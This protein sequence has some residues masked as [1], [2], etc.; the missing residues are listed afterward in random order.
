MYKHIAVVFIVAGLAITIYAITA[1]DSFTD[2]LK[3][4]GDEIVK[5]KSVTIALLGVILSVIGIAGVIRERRSA[6]AREKKGKKSSQ[7]RPGV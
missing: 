4:F 3:E 2:D 1:A 7:I 6:L 5:Y